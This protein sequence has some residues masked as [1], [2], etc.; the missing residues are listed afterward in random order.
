MNKRKKSPN[1]GSLNQRGRENTKAVSN[2]KRDLAIANAKVELLRIHTS[3]LSSQN[4]WLI[5]Y[6]M[7]SKS[8]DELQGW[9]EQYKEFM[10]K[11]QEHYNRKRYKE[12]LVLEQHLLFNR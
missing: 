8:I 6:P 12:L 11:Q 9:K 2:L 7:Q 4:E 10:A 3:F 1:W 5:L